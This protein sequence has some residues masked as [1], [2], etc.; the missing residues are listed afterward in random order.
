MVVFS[1]A[2]ADRALN[3]RVAVQFVANLLVHLLESV[4]QIFRKRTGTQELFQLF[5]TLI[6]TCSLTVICKIQRHLRLALGNS[7]RVIEAD[8][9][10]PVADLDVAVN[11]EA[12]DRA[13]IVAA[14]SPIVELVLR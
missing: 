10:Q 6:N 5:S 14:K 13:E 11:V 7:I 4:A 8:H 1:G 12:T 3:L 2:F 9:S